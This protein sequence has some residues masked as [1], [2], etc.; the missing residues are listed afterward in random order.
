MKLYIARLLYRVILMLGWLPPTP[1]FSP[2]SEVS[3]ILPRTIALAKRFDTELPDGISKRNR[4]IHELNR[5][6]P[7][8]GKKTINL[9]IELAAQT[10]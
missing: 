8:A 7:Q 10:L 9:A 2:S 4:V 5:S 1:V 6:Y 3:K